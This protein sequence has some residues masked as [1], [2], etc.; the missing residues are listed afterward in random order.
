MPKQL[1]DLVV[2]VAIARAGSVSG[3][4]RKLRAPKSSVSRALSRLEES[5]RAQLVYR[6]TRQLNLSPAGTALLARAEPL[7]EA[8]AATL[9]PIA[10]A[11]VPSGLLRVTCTV[12]FGAAVMAELVA[13]F[14]ARYPQVQVEVHSSNTLVDLI[15]RGFD[16]GVRI[17]VK[18]SL[19]DSSLVARR[20][21]TLHMRLVAAPAYLARRGTPRTLPELRTH[22]WV[23]YKGAES[24]PFELPRS[25]RLPAKGRVRGDD[26]S[27]VHAATRAGAGIAFLPAF[28]A[29]PE[30]SAGTLVPVLPKWKVSS[31]GVWVVHPPARP[32]PARVSAFRDLVVEALAGAR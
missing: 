25:K 12:D 1:D 15:G 16:L 32:L 3:A 27:F 23:M 13:R 29:D 4:A 7:V 11:E 22:E 17:S 21:G 19:R 5:L 20:V 10:E 26:M 9:E 18:S 6:S 14:V 30:I 8:L 2:F 31:G 24:V 28:L